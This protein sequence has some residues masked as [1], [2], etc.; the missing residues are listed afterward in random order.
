MQNFPNLTKP[1]LDPIFDVE[2]VFEDRFDSKWRRRRRGGRRRG[3]RRARGGRRRRVCAVITPVEV[4]A[5][6]ARNRHLDLQPV[7]AGGAKPHAQRRARLVLQGAA[8]RQDCQ[9]VWAPPLGTASKAGV[10]VAWSSARG[11]RQCSEWSLLPPVVPR[12]RSAVATSSVPFQLLRRI[13]GACCGQ[14]QRP[15]WRCQ[16]ELG[17]HV[18]LTQCPTNWGEHGGS[19]SACMR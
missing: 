1:F 13:V 17:G 9:R 6:V 2:P 10:V 15:W 12:A 14:Q 3:W 19:S 8:L 4:R 18:W 16:P 7:V 5:V 11:H